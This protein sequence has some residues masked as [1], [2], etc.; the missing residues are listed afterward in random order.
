MTVPYCVPCIARSIVLPR[1]AGESVM[2]M[3]AR[4]IASNFVGGDALAP[5]MMAPAWPCGGR[6]RRGSGDEAIDGS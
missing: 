3:P 4:R 2:V 1:P 5:E 6:A